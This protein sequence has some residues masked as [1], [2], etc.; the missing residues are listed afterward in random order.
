MRRIVSSLSCFS[1]TILLLAAFSPTA[2]A[3]EYSY[4][5]IVRLS[6]VSGDVQLNRDG[7]S[8]W[9]Q[10]V[11]NMPIEQG[12]TIGTND[13]RAEVEFEDG[14]TVWIAE[15]TVVQ[16]TELALSDG[17][18]ISHLTMAQGTVTAFANVKDA[19]SFAITA[20]QLQATA[21]KHALFRVD[22]FHDGASISVFGGSILA[23]SP[24]GMKMVPK[25]GSYA[26]NTKNADA[27]ALRQN[28]K[29]DSWDR[30]VSG[31]EHAV[32]AAPMQS[33]Y[34]AN[35][36]FTYGM[37][38]LAAYGNWN[39]FPGYGYG[40]QPM[41]MGNCWMPFMD[42]MWDSYPGLGWTWVSSEPWGWVPYHFGSWNYSPAYGWMW[43]PGDMNAWNPAPV[44]WYD[45]GNQVAWSPEM[46]DFG[47]SQMF[48]T[49]LGGF[50]G[51]GGSNF[52]RPVSSPRQQPGA[53]NGSGSGSGKVLRGK[54]P[55]PPRFLL[56]AG[57]Q[58]GGSGRVRVL[59][60]GG[61]MMSVE[62][63]HAPPLANGKMVRMG[64][65]NSEA[66][67]GQNTRVLVT[68]A[69]NLNQIRGGMRASASGSA[70]ARM[71]LPSAPMPA[72]MPIAS[73]IRNAGLSRASMPHPP[74]PMRFTPSSS[75]FGTRGGFSGGGSSGGG[76][77]RG[78]SGPSFSAPHS[79]PA[80]PAPHA[81]S[82]KPH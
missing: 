61:A 59:A 74:A 13:G 57:K 39:Y 1:L 48:L 27:A 79:A 33:A 12:F 51:C 66:G 73:P 8:N 82:G 40:W 17:G 5:R 43:M 44:Q 47:Q 45:A 32:Q 76:S 36:S 56:T 23:D 20:S 25:G 67:A 28:P 10:A 71:R 15:N 37:A 26:F 29:P 19:D 69:A 52:G 42:G 75:T 46:S 54:L 6:Y 35:S 63:L 21:S 55:V 62:A 72:A 70:V 16:F 4:A 80:A 11:A 50:G 3:A 64:E 77:F 9:E 68:T 7:H 60:A 30:W 2:L 24:A 18:R 14:A 81:S 65:G 41:G 31:R 78:G 53:K 49:G 22:A 34:F 38:D 58:L